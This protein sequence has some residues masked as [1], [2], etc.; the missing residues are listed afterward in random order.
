MKTDKKLHFL[1]GS[2]MAFIFG[3]IFSPEWGLAVAMTIG[4]AK[5]FVWDGLMKK[6]AVEIWDAV[7]TIVGGVLA[8]LIMLIF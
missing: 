2:V 4:T 8:Y 3:I 5:E 1:A 7:V 6:G